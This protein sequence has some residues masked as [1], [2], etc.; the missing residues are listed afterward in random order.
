MT[1]FLLQLITNQTTRPNFAAVAHT[2]T[3]TDTDLIMLHEI[4]SLVSA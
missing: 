4:L 1:S 2:Q 3:Q